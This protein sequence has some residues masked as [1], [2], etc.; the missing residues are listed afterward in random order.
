MHESPVSDTR[1]PT[2]PQCHLPGA[3]S[4]LWWS[5]RA[6]AVL[7]RPRCRGGGCDHP[8]ASRK[9]TVRAT[10]LHLTPG[11]VPDTWQGSLLRMW[12]GVGCRVSGVGCRVIE[13]S[14]NHDQCR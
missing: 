13:S 5:T 12:L 6:C 8:T 11:R 14:D 3:P 10:H 2:P 1:H 4:F 9:R 7:L